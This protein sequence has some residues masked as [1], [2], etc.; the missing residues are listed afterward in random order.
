MAYNQVTCPWCGGDAYITYEEKRMYL[1]SCKTCDT[2]VFHKDRSFSAA[3]AFF[4]ELIQLEELNRAGRLL[5]LPSVRDLCC[6]CPGAICPG[7]FGTP[8]P[9]PSPCRLTDCYG[10]DRNAQ[11]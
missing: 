7:I 11:L 8:H 9:N 10:G 4:F 3:E 5:T 1:L 6:M 2:A